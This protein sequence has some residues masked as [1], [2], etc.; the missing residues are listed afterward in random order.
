MIS[1]S[2]PVTYVFDF[3]SDIAKLKIKSGGKEYS[4]ITLTESCVYMYQHRQLNVDQIYLF[5]HQ[6]G[7]FI[8]TTFQSISM[9]AASYIVPV[10]IFFF[11]MI[12]YYVYESIH[13]YIRNLVKGAQSGHRFR[14]R[15][16]GSQA[17]PL[18]EITVF[19]NVPI[20]CQDHVL[21]GT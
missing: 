8:H 21:F 15:C 16:K 17:C 18:K 2:V 7:I 19:E 6:N 1:G 14:V 5:V 20:G 10:L 9:L 3:A 13:Y 11:K 4:E 12:L